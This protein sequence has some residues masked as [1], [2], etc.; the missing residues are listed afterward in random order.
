MKH[1]DWI[2]G[3]RIYCETLV[4]ANQQTLKLV[5]MDCI[6]NSGDMEKLFLDISQNI[7]RLI[8]C[9]IPRNTNDLVLIK[10]DGILDFI[11]DFDFLEVDYDKLFLNNRESLYILKVIR[12][13]TEH[14]PHK[15]KVRSSGSGNTSFSDVTF[16]LGNDKLKIDSKKIMKILIELNKI[17]IKI[18]DKLNKYRYTLNEDSRDHPYFK[19][20]GSLDFNRYNAIMESNL[21]YD[22]S[23]ILQEM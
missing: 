13:K 7:I 18:I 8:P 5:A 23:K 12:N 1:G 16:E 15:L 2:N 21:I 10:Q 6:D 9:K 14:I 11:L 22:I 4:E 19:K 20:Y 17:F 3:I